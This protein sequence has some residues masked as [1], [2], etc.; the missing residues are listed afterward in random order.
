MS[1][2]RTARPAS[3][4]RFYCTGR[5]EQSASRRHVFCAA[6]FV[7]FLASCGGQDASTGPP[8]KPTVSGA[9]V[10]RQSG[11]IAPLH[12]PPD[13]AARPLQPGESGTVYMPN[14][15]PAL[16][17]HGIRADLLFVEKL[18][19]PAS[20]FDR[21]ENA[22]MGIRQEFDAVKPAIIRLAAVEEDMQILLRQL[23]TLVQ[24]APAPV[25]LPPEGDRDVAVMDAP[26]SP[27]SENVPSVMPVTGPQVQNLRIG[28]HGDVTRLVLDV[29]AAVAYHHDL[30]NGEHLLLVEIPGAMWSSAMQGTAPPSSLIE[31]WTAQPLD[32]GKGMRLIIRLRGNA[33]VVKD[34][35]LIA[36]D[37][38]MIDL[39]RL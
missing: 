11:E 30:D 20:R 8:H 27:P 13:A 21:L 33:V 31:T 12:I 28:E 37:R 7:F 36:P 4:G 2:S 22:V 3:S 26:S 25:P 15:L 35:A 18:T 14:G 5:K 17:S 6:L 38:I 9:S 1:L 16:T 19:D 10:T 39:K 24:N 32:G 23:E 29:S 34:T